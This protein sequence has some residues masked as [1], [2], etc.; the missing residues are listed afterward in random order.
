MSSSG[1]YDIEKMKWKKKKKR[2]IK[3]NGENS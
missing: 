3:Y 1:N 2:K